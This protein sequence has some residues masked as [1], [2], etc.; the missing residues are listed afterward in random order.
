MAKN[1]YEVFDEFAEANSKEEKL[2]VLHKNWTPTLVS[3]LQLAYHPDVKWLVKDK[4]K[5]YKKPDTLPGVSYSSMNAELRR[6]Y[7]FREGDPAAEKLTP[8]KREQLLLIML[9]SLEPREAD[10]VIGIFKKNLGVKG[11]TYK[12]IRDNTQGVVP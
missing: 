11:L 9:E 5:S 3:V 12:F 4:P 1:L 6:L 2:K 10:V 7:L 8:E